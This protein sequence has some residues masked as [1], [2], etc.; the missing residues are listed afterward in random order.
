LY[1]SVRL[2]VVALGCNAVSDILCMA[3]VCDQVNFRINQWW[4]GHWVTVLC[5]FSTSV[6]ST[7]NDNRI[8]TCQFRCLICIDVLDF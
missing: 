1:A 4:W 2:H 8:F 3:M 5:T 7:I 6:L